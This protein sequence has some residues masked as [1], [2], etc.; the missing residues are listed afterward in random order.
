MSEQ[1]LVTLRRF[2]VSNQLRPNKVTDP[3]VLAAMETVERE[4]FVPA[5]MERL[6]Y[7]DTTV[8]LAG[9]RGLNPPIATGRLLDRAR[10]VRGERALLIG[11]ATGYVAALLAA[12]GASVVAVEEDPALLAVAREALA[13]Q[14]DVRL[15]EGPLAA[16]WPGGAPY[17]LIYLDGAVEEIPAALSDQLAPDGR[18]VG[19]VLERSISR[20]V[21]GRRAGGGFG[22]AG[23]A[24][25]ELAP[26]PGFARAP[27]FAF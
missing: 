18:L 26:L 6:C 15:V 7:R 9:G 20:L 5:G 12:I 17:D 2:M 27:A 3:A 16:G 21:E 24:D 25:V 22:L 23:F 13:G 11:A 10:I 1:D 4:R 8:R 14:A 19:G